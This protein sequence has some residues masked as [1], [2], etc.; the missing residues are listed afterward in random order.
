M[1]ACFSSIYK[2]YMGVSLFKK[3]IAYCA[4]LF[5]LVQMNYVPPSLHRT[6]FVCSS[7]FVS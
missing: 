2:E 1:K 4:V 6:I 3:K 5:N 7:F